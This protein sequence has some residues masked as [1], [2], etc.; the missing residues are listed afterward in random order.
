M[1]DEDLLSA[2]NKYGGYLEA[3]GYDRGAIVQHF[4]SIRGIANEALVNSTKPSD[5]SFK[6]PLVIQMHPA[7]PDLRNIINKFHSVLNTCPIS[8]QVFP[9]GSIFPAFRKLPSLSTILL[10]NPFSP[11]PTPQ[12]NG[13]FPS[14]NC[15]CKV[16]KEANFCSTVASP[17]LPERGF[18]ITQHLNCRSKMVVY[19]IV[20]KL[21]DKAYVGQTQDPRQRWSSHKSHIRLAIASCNMATHCSTMHSV[22]MVGADKLLET[23]TIRSML[24]YTVLE[25]A[26]DESPVTLSRLEEKWRNNMRSWTPLGLNSRDDGPKELRK[27]DLLRK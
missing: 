20:C 25:K 9:V 17:V 18:Q 12:A 16:C 24:Q 7:L 4:N 10:K 21:C 5:S 13:F 26:E 19:L 15:K 14:P 27:K 23:D 11:K 22:E 2:L 1:L 8:S 6:C 3:S